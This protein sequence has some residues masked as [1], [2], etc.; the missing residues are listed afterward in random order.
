VPGVTELL[1]T[2]EA[3]LAAPDAHRTLLLHALARPTASARELLGVPVGQRDADLYALRTSLFGGCIPVVL[4]CPQCAEEMEFDFDADQVIRAAAAPPGPVRVEADGWTVVLR[5]PTP[6]DLLAASAA[7]TAAEA[8]RTLL[9]RCI[10]SASAPAT[11]VCNPVR[12]SVPNRARL[13]GQLDVRVGVVPANLHGHRTSHGA[14][15][16]DLS[17]GQPAEQ[18][19][20]LDDL[21]PVLDD[22]PD[23][24]DD[25]P[26]VLDDL[27]PVLR[28]RA[29]AALAAA[30]PCADIRLRV[31]C[32]EC[33][34]AAQAELDIGS[35]LWAELDAWAR[36]T[37]L[38]VHLL[39]STYGWTE[40]DV[41]AL[42][43][44]RRRYYLELAGH[45]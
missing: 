12:P 17:A 1:E 2:W 30:D 34:H 8:G 32:P 42:S 14:Q 22:L 38:D 26:P 10:V 7:A 15:P 45:A 18:P 6:D 19:P 23:V 27:P 28:E 4:T 41:L 13:G 11:N 31:H 9:A 39:A 43:P 40:P 33:G 36:A 5:L 24:V 25:L 20:M 29:A 21:P 35:C 16:G 37:L 44:V 3:G